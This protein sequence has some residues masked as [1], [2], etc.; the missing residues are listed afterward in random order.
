MQI[1]QSIR[2]NQRVFNV[3]NKNFDKVDVNFESIKK[4]MKKLM[5]GGR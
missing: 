1:S 4:W 2:I 3:S 5:P